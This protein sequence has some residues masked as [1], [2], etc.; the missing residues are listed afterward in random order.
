M[1]N[2]KELQNISTLLERI[3]AALVVRDPG[4]SRAAETFD[5]LR[6]QLNQASKN[7][8]I[9]VSHLLNLSDSI[10]RGAEFQL[11]KDRVSDFLIELGISRLTDVS[12][13]SFFEIKGGSGEYL[14]CT[15]PAVVETLDDGTVSLVRLGE[16]ERTSDSSSGL[17]QIHVIDK[18]VDV[19]NESRGVKIAVGI[20]IAIVGFFFG[21]VIATNAQ[22]H[23]AIGSQNSAAITET[24][25]R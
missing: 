5:G 19:Q 23:S 7:R 16:A 22:D 17:K 6:K 2:K 1:K 13:T 4:N 18:E 21:W 10:E 20:T 8:R 3:D 11:V 24:T 25:E 9:H 15:V 12:Q 14:K